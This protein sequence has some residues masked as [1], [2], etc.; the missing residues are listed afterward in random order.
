MN[1]LF[2]KHPIVSIVAITLLINLV[3]GAVIYG[4]V[5]RYPEVL[6]HMIQRGLSTSV[7]TRDS[8]NIPYALL[9]DNE[10]RVVDVVRRADPAVVA[11]TISKDVPVYERYLRNVPSPFEDF[12]GGDMFN[13]GVP[14][15]RQRGTERREIGGGSGFIVSSDGYIVTNRHVVDD[16]D[17]EYTV[18]RNDGTSI[19][20]TV[21][22]RDPLFDLAILKIEGEN[23]PHVVFGNSDTL[24]VGQSVIAIGNAL[25]EFRN[26]VSV[27]IVSGLS[28]SIIASDGRG[29]AESLDQLIQTDA[30]I[31]QGNS[32]GP[33][34][35]LQGEVIGVNVAVANG[36]ENIGFA[37]AGNSVKDV[38]N[39]VRDTG[40]ITRPYLGVRYAPVTKDVQRA[41]NLEI[42]YGVIVGRGQNAA[43]VAVIS[44]SPADKAGIVENDIILE[45][46]GTKL[47]ADTNLAA[48]VRQKKVGDTITLRVLHRGD[49]KDVR[50]TLEA[51]R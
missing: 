15:V 19:T 39:S 41:N 37:I 47:T 17:A 13:F 6:T 16:S 29:M 34:F 9:T 49:E 24:V 1:P 40:T 2:S 30:A 28:R 11:I 45:I 32:G 46:D 44:G 42:D 35:N 18:F 14:D 31:N 7:Q 3:C 10:S 5:I 8:E 23:F 48:L 36:A 33:L 38:V 50:V 25:A 4:Y 27:G 12:F 21:V 22:A 20:A 43:D 51:L 26:T